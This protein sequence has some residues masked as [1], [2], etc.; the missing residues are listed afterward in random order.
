MQPETQS[1]GSETVC[2]QSKIQARD[3][4]KSLERLRQS[5]QV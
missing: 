5:M 1:K 4:R 2:I 3:L